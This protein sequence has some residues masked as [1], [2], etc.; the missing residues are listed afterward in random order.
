MW[1]ISIFPYCNCGARRHVE[2]LRLM[3]RGICSAN[4]KVKEERERTW[5]SSISCQG[6]ERVGKKEVAEFVEEA[7]EEE[8]RV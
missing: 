1:N 6:G 7:K 3:C 2:K 4:R 5:G 8:R